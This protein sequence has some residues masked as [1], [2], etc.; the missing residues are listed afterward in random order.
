MLAGMSPD[1]DGGNSQLGVTLPNELKTAVY[2]T[3]HER[4]VTM[5]EV[6]REA[7]KQWF[8]EQSKDELPELAVE[9]LQDLKI[10]PGEAGEEASDA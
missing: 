3:A 4:R 6:T 8:E 9:N 1:M 7:L 2:E 5:S 10:T